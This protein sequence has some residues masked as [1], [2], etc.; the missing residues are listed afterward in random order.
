MSKLSSPSERKRTDLLFDPELRVEP[1]T[2]LHVDRP[3]T[4][5]YSVGSSAPSL[6]PADIVV[7]NSTRCIMLDA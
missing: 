5:R 1:L 4:S 3:V 6:L 7:Y 2:L